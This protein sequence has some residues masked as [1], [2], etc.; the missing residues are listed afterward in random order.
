[1]YASAKVPNKPRPF[2]FNNAFLVHRNKN[3]KKTMFRNLRDA[4][5]SLHAHGAGRR[6]SAWGGLTGRCLVRAIG[7][8]SSLSSQ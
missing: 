4:Q 2:N 5:V 1:M 7:C 8:W 3:R 6:Q